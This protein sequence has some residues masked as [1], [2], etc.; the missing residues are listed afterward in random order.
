[1]LVCSGLCY[2]GIITVFAIHDFRSLR[3]ITGLKF[4]GAMLSFRV[5]GV[6]AGVCIDAVCGFLT[7][8]VAFAVPELERIAEIDARSMAT[9]ETSSWKR[10]C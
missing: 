5:R 3:R 8:A 1:M 7:G 4:V 9:I 10:N 6:S 2:L